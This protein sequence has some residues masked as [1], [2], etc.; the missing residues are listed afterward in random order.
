[1]LLSFRA[2]ENIAL[3]DAVAVDMSTSGYIRTARSSGDLDEANTIGVSVDDVSTG[4]LCR[5]VT[6]AQAVVYSGL[7][8]GTRYFVSA[9]GGKV[10]DYPTYVAGFDQLGA[11]GAYLV[12]LGTAISTGSLRICP[13]QPR[14]VVSGYL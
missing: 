8:P 14:Y 7:I 2:G 13:Q 9:S 1:M 11:S 12:E 5:V 6:D 4:T 3:G 10:V